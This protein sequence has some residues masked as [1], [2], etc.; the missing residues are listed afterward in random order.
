MAKKK[1]WAVNVVNGKDSNY[2]RENSSVVAV[3]VSEADAI[4][5]TKWLNAFHKRGGNKITYHA[6]RWKDDGIPTNVQLTNTKE[7]EIVSYSKMNEEIQISNLTSLFD[8][9][10]ES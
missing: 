1:L 5:E 4:A 2:L 10:Q 9:E 6:V 3:Y 7:T 8:E